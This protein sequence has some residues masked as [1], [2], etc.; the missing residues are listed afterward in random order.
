MLQLKNHAF[1]R[2]NF[3]KAREILPPNSR[4]IRSRSGLAPLRPSATCA[5]TSILLTF[6]IHHYRSV[7]FPHL[8]LADVIQAQIGHNPVNPGIERA[9]EAEASDVLVCLQE[10]FLIDVLGFVLCI[11]SSAGPVATPH[12]RSGA[13]V[14]RRQTRLPRW[15]SRTRSVSSIR[16]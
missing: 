4:R 14:P 1:P 9:L 8:F 12:D 7:F 3:S 6:R 16:L 13:P 11:R 2:V 5:S 15:A 10:R